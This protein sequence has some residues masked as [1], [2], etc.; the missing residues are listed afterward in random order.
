LAG[1]PQGL[2]WID[3]VAVLDA[4]VGAVLLVAGVYLIEPGI[5]DLGFYLEADRY[6]L[7]GAVLVYAGLVL[8][9]AGVFGLG[10]VTGVA[11][12]TANVAFGTIARF[13]VAA[14][15]LTFAVRAALAGLPAAWIVGPAIPGLLALF[16]LRFASIA[17]ARASTTAVTAITADTGKSAP[18]VLSAFAWDAV[19]LGVATCA[20]V[21]LLGCALAAYILLD[22]AFIADRPINLAVAVTAIWRTLGPVVLVVAEILVLVFVFLGTLNWVSERRRRRGGSE[23]ERDLGADELNFASACVTQIREY[24]AA[25]DLAGLAH[26]ASSA[27]VWLVLAAVAFA[28]WVMLEAERLIGAVYAPSVDGWSLYLIEWPDAAVVAL[29]AIVSAAIVPH[30]L[31]KLIWPRVAEASG[32][33]MLKADRADGGLDREIVKRVRDRSLAPGVAFDAGELM[34]VWGITTAVIA[35]VWNALIAAGVVLWWPH[36]RARDTLYTDQ[37]IETGDFWTMER[38]VYPYAA[39]QAV[40]LTCAYDGAQV[41]YAIELPD[42]LRRDVLM[43]RRFASRL[44]DAVLI[45]T[46]LRAA[47]VPFQ[48]ALPEQASVSREGVV[49][50][51]CV[52][53]LTEGADEETRAKI[54]QVFHLDAWFERRWRLRTGGQPR[55]SSR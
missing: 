5:A 52:L 27:S 44:D 24:V 25:R 15:M 2:R 51:W 22:R 10:G 40:H 55:I 34:R 4:A 21:F 29:V 45:D 8:G 11:G 19:R 17:K 30:A 13:C 46:K 50:R 41:G 33:L 9:Y 26:R 36:D 16:S 3:A 1:T 37:G 48:F 53:A 49:S 39:V 20:G 6:V 43:L 47:G 12:A 32:A 54:E 18:F 28:V 14:L 35:L 42:G 38:G 7:A 23:V 31:A